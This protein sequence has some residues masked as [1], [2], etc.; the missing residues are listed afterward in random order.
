MLSKSEF[1][2]LVREYNE[3]V[4]RYNHGR[5]ANP[6]EVLEYMAKSFGLESSCELDRRYSASAYHE[7]DGYSY[8]KIDRDEVDDLYEMLSKGH[9]FEVREE[10][11]DKAIRYAYYIQDPELVKKVLEEHY[12]REISVHVVDIDNGVEYDV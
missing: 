4:A 6:G 7:R 8:A 10:L 5:Y 11:F 12:G 3:E 9:E 2:E 1:K